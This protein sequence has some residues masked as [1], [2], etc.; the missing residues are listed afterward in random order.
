VLL[1]KAIQEVLLLVVDILH[2][3]LEAAAELVV[4]VAQVVLMEWADKVD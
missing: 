4:Q 2:L 1:G 3:G